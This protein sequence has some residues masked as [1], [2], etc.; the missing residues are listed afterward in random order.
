MGIIRA[1]I[2]ALTA[3]TVAAGAGCADTSLSGPNSPA[4]PARLHPTLIP[5]PN[6]SNAVWVVAPLGLNVHNQPDLNSDKVATISPGNELLVTGSRKQ[7]SQSWLH[8]KT[9]SG[10]TQGWIVDQPDLVSHREVKQQSDAQDGYSILYPAG[11]TLQDGN[12]ATFTAPPG[13]PHAGKL[14]VQVADDVSKLPPVPLNGGKESSQ[15]ESTQPIEVYGVTAFIS[16][17]QGTDGS[18]EFLVEK[19][20]G[21]KVYLFDFQ[22]PGR[23]QPDQT[24]FQQ[25]LASVIVT[26]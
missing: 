24:Q 21:S 17:Y 9:Q 2:G 23:A 20:I 3:L 14:V 16:V 15:N 4:S 10:S 22:Q 11:W 7:G 12:P 6:Q 18:W 19:K 1:A 26:G 13:D 25:L 5:T 8:V